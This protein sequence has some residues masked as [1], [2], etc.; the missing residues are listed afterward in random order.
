M[1]MNEKL[2]A[3]FN[4]WV[5]NGRS[6]ALESH[7]LSFV[8]DML[9]LMG[10]GARDRI[11]EV[12]CGEGWASRLFSSLVPEGLVVGL[13]VSDE[14]IHKARAAS[15]AHENILFVW[16]DAESIPWQEKFFSRAFSIESFYYVAEPQVALREIFRVLSPGGSVWILN[17]LSQENEYTLRW[18][19]R[20]QAPVQLRSAEEYGK[21]FESCGFEGYSFRMIPDRTPDADAEYYAWLAD[22]ADRRRFREQG[23]L[24]MTARRPDE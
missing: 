17:H 15:A 22:P 21:L 12:G 5:Q 3:E 14:M 24:L 20:L 6:A 19:D 13:D 2:R 4:R 1:K 10:I 11:L 9:P 8:E 16:A 23:A 7:H 18:L